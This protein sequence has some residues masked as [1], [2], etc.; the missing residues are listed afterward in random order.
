MFVMSLVRSRR[1]GYLIMFSI[2]L[3]T[4]GSKQCALFA[5]FD[6]SSKHRAA[7]RK[8]LGTCLMLISSHE[9]YMYMATSLRLI[10]LLGL[11]T[12]AKPIP[13]NNGFLC[14]AFCDI[15]MCSHNCVV[16]HCKHG[17]SEACV[18]SN[19]YDGNQHTRECYKIIKS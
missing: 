13:T 4:L 8:S 12:I 2:Y 17:L 10:V 9:F 1:T 16:A 3:R 6:V 7:F 5:S 15:V 18:M 11:K 14:S 19:V